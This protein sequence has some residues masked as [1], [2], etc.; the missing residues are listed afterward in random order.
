M[1][2]I[3]WVRAQEEDRVGIITLDRPENRNAIDDEM[4]ANLHEALDWAYGRSHLLAL[5]VT[6]AGDTFCAGADLHVFKKGWEARAKRL[7]SEGAQEV[8][9]TMTR[10]AELVS[11]IR[12]FPYPVIAALNG[13]AVGGG[14]GLALA[15]DIRIASSH[16]RLGVGFIRMGASG[17]VMGISYFLPR[18]VGISRALELMTTGEILEAP[19]AEGLGLV[20]RVVAHERLRDEA[21][22]FGKRIASMPPM[23]LR[24]SKAA[25]NLHL[26]ATLNQALS[27]ENHLQTQCLLSQDHYEGMRAFLEKRPP[28]FEGV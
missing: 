9:S 24:A 11:R 22:S 7:P 1:T 10:L 8:L 21:L 17:A 19:R 20:N 23:G 18:L 6:G 14:F 3:M 4:L 2:P 16:A 15:C 25:L 27:H 13:P 12:G 28:H 26:D 5:I